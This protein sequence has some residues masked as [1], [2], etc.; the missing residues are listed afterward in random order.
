MIE[1]IDPIGE[2]YVN[3]QGAVI[4]L[5]NEIRNNWYLKVIQKEWVI[6]RHRKIYK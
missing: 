5:N 4:M 2:D 1:E 3:Y 6:H